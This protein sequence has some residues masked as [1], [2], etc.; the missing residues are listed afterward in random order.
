MGEVT[1]LSGG[2]KAAYKLG[3][4]HARRG[5]KMSDTAAKKSFGVYHPYYALGHK[6]MSSDIADSE[7]WHSKQ[8]VRGGMVE[9]DND[10]CWKGYEQFGTKEKNGKKVPNC[11]PVSEEMD[12][13]QDPLLSKYLKLRK[14]KRDQAE[15][16]Q[17][18][19]LTESA[20]GQRV[21]AAL[22]ESFPMKPLLGTM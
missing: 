14:R 3:K 2:Q 12:P 6:H 21:I 15:W 11:V 7:A 19:S 4:E 17:L 18:H 10:P 5:T 20:F 8:R 9:S 1:K 22:S 16:Y 13:L